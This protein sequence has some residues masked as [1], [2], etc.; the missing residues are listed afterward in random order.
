MGEKAEKKNVGPVMIA[1]IC[2]D[3][4]RVQMAYSS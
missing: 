4:V 2:E 1:F 3:D